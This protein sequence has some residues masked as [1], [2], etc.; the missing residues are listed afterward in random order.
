MG[1]LRQRS[2]WLLWRRL[3]SVVCR[4]LRRERERER[5]RERKEREREKERERMA[6]RARQYLSL[7]RIT[8]PPAANRTGLT[9][10]LTCQRVFAVPPRFHTVPE[11][12]GLSTLV[13]RS[14]IFAYSVVLKAAALKAS[15][16]R[17]PAMPQLSKTGAFP[18]ARQ[19]LNL[20]ISAAVPSC[21]VG[22]PVQ[23]SLSRMSLGFRPF[24]SSGQ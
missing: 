18:G 16:T 1:A 10:G 22:S 15:V 3:T 2:D 4:Q 12:R 8:A 6:T 24:S 23:Y 11:G 5:E 19:G 21:Q 14:P 20:K 17:P 9:T 7:N 13:P